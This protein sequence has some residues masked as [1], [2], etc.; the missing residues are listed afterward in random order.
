MSLVTNVFRR[1]AVFHFRT[2]VPARLVEVVGRK[3]LWRSLRTGDQREARQRAS[4]AILLT[5]ALWRDLERIMSSR[6]PSRSEIKAKIDQWLK[7][8][9]DRDEWLRR[10]SEPDREGKWWPAAILERDGAGSLTVVELLDQDALNAL[11]GDSLAGRLKRLGP[12]RQLVLGHNE[13]AHERGVRH[14]LHGDAVA[15]HKEADTSIAKQVLDALLEKLTLD[16]PKDGE[17]YDTAARMMLAAQKELAESMAYRQLAGAGPGGVSA[18]GWRPD[19]D[20]D[21]A[22]DLVSRLDRPSLGVVVP[23]TPAPQ[24]IEQ[25]KLSGRASLRLSAAA[26]EAIKDLARTARWRPGR[27][28]D[29]RHAVRT[30]IDWH[31]SDPSL[32]EITPDLAGDFRVA[33][34]KYP[35]NA[36]KRRPYRNLSTFSER[37]AESI[38]QNETSLL[39]PVS[40]NGRYLTPLRTIFDWHAA[41]GSGL[42]NPFDKVRVLVSRKHDPKKARRDFTIPELQRFFDLPVFTGASRAHGSGSAKPGDIRIRDWRYWVPLISIFSGMRLNEVCGLAI[43]DLKYEG[44][45]AYFHV[46]DEHEGQSLK[47]AASRRKVPIH[48]ELVSLGLVDQLQRWKS[49]GR[50]RLFEELVPD[51]RGYFSQPASRL[52]NRWIDRIA[53]VDPDEPGELVFY[54]TRHTVIT[55]LRAAHARQDVSQ[56]LVGHETG[57]VHAGYGKSD[58]PTLK[59]VVDKIE[60]A[61]LDLSRLK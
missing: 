50:S 32:G 6:V 15:R 38:R 35:T 46:R 16:L 30:F 53:D 42:D 21:P 45:I 7:A 5:D 3:E 4:R 37:L 31:G 2:R 1:G 29:Y 48:H 44:E 56:D 55:R 40:V 58:V 60:Y 17:A 19:L 11:Q 24:E 13:I 59:A 9:L 28:D 43:A 47:A 51:R 61:G 41:A 26:D 8:E 12:G 25:P 34:G 33:M 49:E 39:D 52:F 18:T 10:A 14:E 27:A 57:D 54:S 22:G 23:M 36:T 20:K